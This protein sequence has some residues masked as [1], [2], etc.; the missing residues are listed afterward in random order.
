MCLNSTLLHNNAYLYSQ[1]IFPLRWVANTR[2]L[3]FKD[4][5][6][7]LL[8]LHLSFHRREYRGEASHILSLHPY[9]SPFT[10]H[11]EYSPPPTGQTSKRNKQMHLEIAI[12]KKKNILK[13]VW[14][15]LPHIPNL[16]QNS[17][18]DGDKPQCP[19]P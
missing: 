7:V 9:W 4:T 8:P 15:A 12:M 1:L 17:Y 6:L 2:R 5:L 3:G 10:I 13:N 19:P 14:F 11:R 18:S 16:H